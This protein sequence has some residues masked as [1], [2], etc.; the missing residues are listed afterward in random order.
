[1]A[2]S[3]LSKTMTFIT[4]YEPNMSSAQNLVNPLIPDSS[5]VIISTR[6]K[7]AQKSDCEV[8]NKLKKIQK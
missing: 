1:M 5:K 6:P 3:I 4:E 8:S 7:L 2:I